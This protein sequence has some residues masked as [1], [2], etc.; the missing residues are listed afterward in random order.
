MIKSGIFV[1]DRNTS[2]GRSAHNKVNS[3]FGS[4]DGHSKIVFRNF[5]FLIDPD[6]V[7]TPIDD[8]HV[9]ISLEYPGG[10]N[11]SNVALDSLNVTTMTQNSNV[12]VG[13]GHVTGMDANEKD[14]Y[15]QG[16]LYGNANQSIQNT[17]INYDHDFIDGTILDQDIKVNNG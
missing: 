13:K 1:G 15:G 11:I 7:D 3:V 17:N 5:S 4:I 2:I 9:H 6:Y 12:F 8:R 10:E 16:A 14:N